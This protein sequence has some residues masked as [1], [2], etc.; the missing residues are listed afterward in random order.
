L[1][2]VTFEH[3]PGKGLNV[4]VGFFDLDIAVEILEAFWLH[5]HATENCHKPQNCELFVRLV[6]SVIQGE[7]LLHFGLDPLDSWGVYANFGI[8]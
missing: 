5:A 7:F 6:S 1:V 3:C 2:I 8:S 4:N